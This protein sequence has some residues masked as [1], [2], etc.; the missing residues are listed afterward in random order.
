METAW[1]IPALPFASFVVNG[2]WGRRLPKRGVGLVACGAMGL[3]FVWVLQLLWRLLQEAPSQRSWE[4][5][6]YTWMRVGE[7]QVD[8]S[9][10][11]DPLSM[12]MMLVVTGVGFLIHVYSWLH[13]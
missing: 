9:F 10:L 2:L 5:V 4:P 11:I 6:L 1:I 13:A 7:F 8:A 3:A 12:V